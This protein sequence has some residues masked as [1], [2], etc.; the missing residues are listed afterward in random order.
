[1]KNKKASTR[2]MRTKVLIIDEGLCLLPRL[3]FR[4]SHK[5]PVSMVD[6]DLFDKL[7][8]IGAL[9][10]KSP[11]PFGGIQVRLRSIHSISVLSFIGHRYG[12]LLPAASR[13]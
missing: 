13:Q 2:W 7:S 4:E 9:M 10:R 8:Q 5:E 3:R 6:A 12:R 1:M 11:R